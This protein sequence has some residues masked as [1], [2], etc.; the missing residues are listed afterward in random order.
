[1]VRPLEKPSTPAR[2][3]SLAETAAARI[4]KEITSGAVRP[5]ERLPPERELAERLGLSRG[6]LREGLR[7]LE[8][9]GLVRARVGQ[10]RFVTDAGADGPTRALS[11]WMQLQP[12]GDISAVRRLLE[13]AAVR[14]M[15]AAQVGATTEQLEALYVKMRSAKRRGAVGDAIKLH[16]EFHL[17]IVRYGSTRLVR[18]LLSS[19]IEA[20]EAWQP[21]VLRDRELAPLW[22]SGHELILA[23]MRAGDVDGAA[24]AVERHLHTVVEWD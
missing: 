5:G 15:P 22:L 14:D 24:D 23:A 2:T 3:I 9:V 11:A 17:R 12:S 18:S 10:G 21:G 7:T 8:S 1:M 6:A 19:M 16:S 20:S 13:P 4:A